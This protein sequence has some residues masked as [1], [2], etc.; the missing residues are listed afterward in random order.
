M[1]IAAFI[2]ARGGSKAIPRKNII[3]F[4]GQPLLSWSIEQAQ[5]S[6]YINNV[7]VSSDDDEILRISENYG[8]KSVKRPDD[9][10]GDLASSESALLHFTS[11]LK[12][13]DLVVFL[14]ATSPLREPCDLDGAIEYFLMHNYDSLFSANELGDMCIWR[15]KNNKLKSYNY[16]YKNRQRR[17]DLNQEQLVENGSFYLFTPK[18]LRKYKNR[19]G[20]KIGY[21]LMENWK[22][23]EVDTPEDLVLCEFMF[24]QKGLN[25]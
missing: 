25:K 2:P 3:E 7:Y 17:Q 10:S 8:A 16:N 21:F 24:K 1:N 15:K 20:G 23:H 14:Q 12:N 18:C 9:I 19:L 13:V 5:A 22:I 6:E 11:H 4:A